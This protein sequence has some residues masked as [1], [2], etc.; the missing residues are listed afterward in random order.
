VADCGPGG[1]VKPYLPA[2]LRYEDDRDRADFFIALTQ[3][4][5]D[6]LM[7]GREVAEVDRLGARLSVVLALSHL[8]L[9]T[10]ALMTKDGGPKAN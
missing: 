3:D 4:G 8:Q 7:K 2:N 1:S 6:H 10:K 5:C 9:A